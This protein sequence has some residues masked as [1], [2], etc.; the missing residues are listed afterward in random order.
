[1]AGSLTLSRQ[2]ADL[3]RRES[4]QSAA[5]LASRT[6]ALDAR[7]AELE[8][9]EIALAAA[10]ESFTAAQQ[11]TGIWAEATATE[12]RRWLALIQEQLSYFDHRGTVAT[13]LR[14]L[15]DAAT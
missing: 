9:R 11:D 5:E 2:I 1:M 7:E 14:T 4:A 13:V 6:L 15:R 10:M 3:V 8:R 12:R